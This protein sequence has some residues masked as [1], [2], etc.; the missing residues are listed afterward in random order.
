DLLAPDE[1][2]PSPDAFHYQHTATERAC[3]GIPADRPETSH[4]IGV[5]QSAADAYHTHDVG[6]VF[7][8]L[9]AYAHYLEDEM[10]LEEALDVLETLERVGGDAFRAED[11]VAARLRLARVLRK[12]NR[13]DEA[14]RA[15]EEAGAR[16]AGTADRHS[17]LVSRMGCAYVV[18]ARGN[19]GEAERL[20]CAVL[21]EAEAEG[22][23]EAQALAHQGI[24]VVQSTGGRPAEAIPHAWRA[25][26]LYDDELSRM[27]TLTDLGVMFLTVGDP[28]SAELAL[29][30]VVRESS[31]RDVIDNAMIDLMHC[32]SFRRDRVGFERWRE[33]CEARREDMPPNVLVDFTLKAAIGRARFGQ[34]S[35]ADALLRT[36]LRLA[37]D[38]GLHEFVFR[39]ERIRDGLRD[40]KEGCSCSPLAATE[41]AFGSDVLREVS[42]GLASLG[43]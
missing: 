19:L 22:D 9:F 15:Y 34:F 39:I 7:P 43:R 2:T 29:T 20:L 41:P 4:L 16:A 32:A 38:A 14:E 3:R 17:Q 35:R 27:R 31:G 21:H 30:T 24:A 5:V 13:F 36:A 28:K 11:R 12:L 1:H 33:R 6:L 42:N 10:R 40:C 25:Y 8:A 18:T 37:E 26:E 23:S